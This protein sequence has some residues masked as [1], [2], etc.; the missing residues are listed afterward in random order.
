MVESWNIFHVSSSAAMTN[1]LSD[2][3]SLGVLWMLE[4][5]VIAKITH[6]D[7]IR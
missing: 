1:Q 4:S 3:G 2:R 5:V 7:E 6:K